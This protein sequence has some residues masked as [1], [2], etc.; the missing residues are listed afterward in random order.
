MDE[1][2]VTTPQYPHLRAVDP[3]V[4]K[5]NRDNARVTP[6]AP[7][8]DEQLLASIRTRGIL[9]LPIVA[10]KDGDL[11][12]RAGHR[13]VAMAIK[14]DLNPI[15]VIETEPGNID[16][17]DS[18]AENLIRAA[19]SPVDTWRRHRQ[20]GET[21]SRLDRTRCRRLTRH[22]RSHGSQAE[23]PCG[24]SSAHA[25]RYGARRHA[26]RRATSDY[27]RRH[28]RRASPGLE[29]IQAEEE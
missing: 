21:Q 15:F 18:L 27:R 13:R 9:Q 25:E 26:F 5:A 6:P 4:L 11:V 8:Q 14:L 16:P 29:K 1:P 17:M 22:R 10:E 28:A 23:A 20:P 3:S 7:A 19:M 24:Y 12:I 2:I